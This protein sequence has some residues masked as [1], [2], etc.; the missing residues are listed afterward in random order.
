MEKMGRGR[1]WRQSLTGESVFSD[2]AKMNSQVKEEILS[3]EKIELDVHQRLVFIDFLMSLSISLIAG[4]F[5][6]ILFWLCEGIIEINI[7]RQDD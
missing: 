1:L 3:S 2:G 6:V 7:F 4:A 5:D